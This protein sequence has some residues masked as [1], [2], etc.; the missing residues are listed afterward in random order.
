M[1][2]QNLSLEAIAKHWTLSVA[3]IRLISHYRKEHRLFLAL[4]LC[5]VRLY[6]RIL[7]NDHELSPYIINHLTKQLDLPP[8]LMVTRPNRQATLTEHRQAILNYLGFKKYDASTEN[9]FVEWINRQIRKGLLPANVVSLAPGYLL[10]LHVIVPGKSILERLVINTSNTL[11]YK[12][13]EAIYH[14]LGEETRSIMNDMLDSLNEQQPSFFNLLKD[15]P[16]SA[17]I[18]SI[19]LYL[20]RFERIRYIDLQ[21]IQNVVS[22]VKLIAYFYTLAKRYNARDLKRFNPYKRYGLLACFLIETRRILLDY[23]V[24]MHDQY[25]MSMNRECRNIHN[26]QRLELRKRRTKSLDIII[27][28]AENLLQLPDNIILSKAFIFNDVD[29]KTLSRS[30]ADMRQIQ[31]IEK[32]GYT[33]ALL[34]RYAS[35]RKY[36]T[37][38]VQLPFKSHDGSEDL[39]NAIYLVRQLNQGTIKYLP[40]QAP[41]QFLPFEFKRSIFL[42][43]G[44]INRHLWEIGLG[45]AIR[46]ALRSG[47]L[48]LPESKKHVSFWDLAVNEAQW[49]NMQEHELSMLKLPHKKDV[50]LFLKNQF[51]TAVTTALKGWKENSFA[52]IV[53]GRLKLKH[54][55][56]LPKAP[57][58]VALQKAIESSLPTIRIEN[59][60]I[61][62]DQLTGF[63][64]HFKPLQGHQ[65]RPKHFYKT[66]IAGIISQA[67]NLGIMATSASVEGVSVDMLRYVVQTYIREETI[68]AASSDLVNAHHLHPLSRCYASGDIASSD[69]QRFGIRASSLLASYYPRYYGYYEKAIGIYTHVSNQSS[70][71]HTQAI[72]CGPREALYV[73][74]GLLENNTILNIKAHTTD[75]GGYT[76]IIFSLCFLLGFYFMPRIRDLKDQQLYRIQDDLKYGEFDVLLR[77]KIDLDVIE[78]QWD[79]MTRVAISLMQRT[80]PAHIIVQRLTSSNPSDRLT[81]AFIN[82]GRLIKTEYI[83]RYLTDK[84]LRRAV[85]QQLNKGE[86]RH[87]IPRWIFFAEQ[88]EFT[89]GDYEEIMN[90]A[91][92]LSLV[93]NAILYWNTLKVQGILDSLHNQG[94][95]IEDETL[96]HISLLPFKHV[97]PNGTYFI[98]DL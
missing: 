57:A 39:I 98:D 59:L 16:P 96:S 69:A 32:N 89:T 14:S 7:Q 97:L 23:L 9:T 36:F 55:D 20:E 46:D 92:C 72:S 3:D 6:G 10:D 64:K 75:T 60:L 11:Y 83:L 95:R 56:K 30:V 52:H 40:K 35:F 74:D 73:L 4:Q 63:T 2:A 28:S 49:L 37:C 67:T 50:K 29:E 54:D 13:F 31:I 34:K 38:F 41:K 79:N 12:V 93:S 48:Y 65:S 58:V 61:E 76:E 8:T 62:V 53:N 77:K 18:K 42:P 21:G 27:K 15:Y 17:T 24:D 22:D 78:E 90:K 80:S 81:K 43:D 51:D 71:F 91:S 47:D 85:Q 84:D 44:R 70:V 94:E 88:G 82:L 19:N 26:T 25:M 68:M 33:D 87:R 86:Y 1:N 45:F 66:L 5:S